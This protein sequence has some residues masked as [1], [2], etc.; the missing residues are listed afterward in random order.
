[1]ADKNFIIILMLI[2][3]LFGCNQQKTIEYAYTG[4]DTVDLAI[5][6]GKIIDG[7]GQPPFMADLLINQ[8]KIVYIGQIDTS[9][10]PV[11]KVIDGSGMIVTPGFIDTHAHGD[12]L[13]TPDFSNFLS[14]GA[15]TICLG[16]D[17][18]SP[19]NLDSY[20]DQVEAIDIGPNLIYFAGH[21]AIRMETGVAYDT[22]P[23]EQDLKSM[24]DLLKKYLEHGCFGLSTGL[25]YNPGY[26]AG[27]SELIYLSK[28]VNS[29]QG[30]IMSHLR[31]EDN[32]AME[33]SL[34]EFFIQGAFCPIHISHLKVVYGKGSSRADQIL[35]ILKEGRQ[36]GIVV[37]ADVYPY[38]A[39]YTGIGIV[40]PE[41]AKPPNNY[42]QVVLQNK[43][44]LLQFVKNRVMQ[45]NGPEATLLGSGKFKGKT[46]K[47]AAAEAGKPFELLLVEDIGPDG[48]SGAYFVMDQELQDTFIKDSLVMIC[49]DGSP[50]ARHPRGHGT[51]ARI[52][53]DY[54]VKDKALDLEYAVFKMTGLPAQTLGLGNRGLIKKGYMADLLIFD[55]EAIQA[56]AT[57][58]EPFQL[59][60]GFDHIIVNGILVRQEGIFLPEKAGKLLRKSQV[61]H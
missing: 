48:A 8:Q 37:T 47:E 4:A 10:I 44:K 19:P 16:Q 17:G 28:I 53:A 14:M 58:E 45:R 2:S 49:S 18:D 22:L 27:K 38:T 55:P 3:N 51:F 31:N 42:E 21:G 15:T 40:F 46:L 29:Y 52:I 34:S 25:E 57:Y 30:L 12:P 26:F 23:T 50:T 13:E 33:A 54:V 1:M 56:T 35:Q 32:D 7:T 9:L 24:G 11:R 60:E 36:K 43:Q 59:A 41:W 20:L 6:N 39:S 61:A 5:I